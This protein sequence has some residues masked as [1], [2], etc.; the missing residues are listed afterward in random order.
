MGIGVIERLNTQIGGRDILVALTKECERV[1]HGGIALQGIADSEP[2]IKDACHEW[3]FLGPRRFALNERGKGDDLLGGAFVRGTSRRRWVE[4]SPD[5]AEFA[6]HHVRDLGTACMA[7]ELI[8]G[9]KKKAFERGSVWGN[10]GDGSRVVGGGKKVLAR[11]CALAVQ[12]IGYVEHCPALGNSDDVDENSAAGDFPEDLTGIERLIEEIFA[13]L[14]LMA[15]MPVAEKREGEAV[16]DDLV[17]AKNARNGP[18]R[19]AARDI[20]K[21]LR[22]TVASVRADDLGVEPHRSC[23]DRSE[24]KQRE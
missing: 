13:G 4:L 3:T 15:E 18:P 21:K 7:R 16:A 1:L 10:I 20:H 9:W 17:A 23:T 5:G 19:C 2:I 12:L 8:G 11:A 14:Q 24:N 6:N 22:G